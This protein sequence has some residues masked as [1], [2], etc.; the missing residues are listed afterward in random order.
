MCIISIAAQNTKTR[1]N[2]EI[3]SYK[4][5]YAIAIIISERTINVCTYFPT[6]TTM[7]QRNIYIH[8]YIYG[9]NMNNTMQ[10]RK[11]QIKNTNDTQKEYFL[12]FLL[13]ISLLYFV[14]FFFLL[15]F[16]LYEIHEVMCSVLNISTI[17]SLKKKTYTSIYIYIC[18]CMYVCILVIPRKKKI[19]RPLHFFRVKDV[20]PADGFLFKDSSESSPES[21][22]LNV[23]GR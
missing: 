1:K 17:S 5:G 20:F 7:T 12:L 6:T 18:I 11:K 16:L 8:I 3:Y 4:E 15:F 2:N 22:S 19:H 21:H 14:A 9:R 23:N 13:F 10:S